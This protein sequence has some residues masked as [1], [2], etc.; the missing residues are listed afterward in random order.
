MLLREYVLS[1]EARREAAAFLGK[2]DEIRYRFGHR[3]MTVKRGRNGNTISIYLQ[4][5][6]KTLQNAELPAD[7]RVW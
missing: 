1:D 2:P 6:E 4:D 5:E 7:S 3:I